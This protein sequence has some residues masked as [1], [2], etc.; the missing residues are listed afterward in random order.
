MGLLEPTLEAVRRLAGLDPALWTVIGVSM[1]VSL[2]AMAIATPFAVAAGYLL[3]MSRFPGRRLLVVLVQSLLSFPTVVVGL[4]LYL[5]LSRQ[6]PFGAWQLLFT[7]EAMAIGQVVSG[8]TG[9]LTLRNLTD[10]TD[11]ATLAW[12]ETSA[13]RKTASVTLPGAAKVYELRLRKSLG[14]VLMVVALAV[15]VALAF[16]QGAGHGAALGGHGY[17]SVARDAAG[18]TAVP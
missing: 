3:A 7:R 5:L 1:Q 10:S 14:I 18:R 11:D 4:L 17:R 15:N 12:T 6:G 2:A 8:V 9:T 16:S 13:T